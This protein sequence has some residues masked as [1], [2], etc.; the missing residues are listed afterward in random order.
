MADIAGEALI[1]SV[2]AAVQPPTVYKILALPAPVVVITPVEEPI[3]ATDVLLL[4]HT[5][6]VVASLNVDDCPIQ[7]L[8]VPL[9]AGA[10][11][12]A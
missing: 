6:P 9:I 12:P 10:E 8:A 1:V 5:P 11:H 2:K 4:V 3:V 7:R